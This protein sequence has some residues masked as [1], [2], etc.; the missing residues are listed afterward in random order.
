VILGGLFALCPP[1]C[2][3]TP[4]ALL[5]SEGCPHSPAAYKAQIPSQPRDPSM[6]WSNTVAG[7]PAPAGQ[8]PRQVQK[9]AC[10]ILGKETYQVP[11]AFR[12]LVVDRREGQRVCGRRF[13]QPCFSLLCSLVGCDKTTVILRVQGVTSCHCYPSGYRYF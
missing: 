7:V 9:N 3:D 8:Y 4:L 10:I 13:S 2:G 6:R 5:L 12:D 1:T 11:D